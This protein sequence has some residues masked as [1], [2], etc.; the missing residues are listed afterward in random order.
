MASRIRTALL[1]SVALSIVST[2]IALAAPVPAT[3][4]VEGATET[5]VKERNQAALETNVADRANGEIRTVKGP[6]AL[7]QLIRAGAATDT[8][9]RTS[10]TDAFGPLSALVERVGPDDQGLNF[11]GPGFWLFKVNHKASDVGANQKLLTKG[12][13]VLWYFSSDF[14]VAEL[15]LGVPTKPV[16][17]GKRFTVTVTAYDGDGKGTPAKDARVAYSGTVRRTN[18][19]GRATFT[20]KR[21][22]RGMRATRG[23]DIRTGVEPMCGYVRAATECSSALP[24]DGSL[25]VISGGAKSIGWTTSAP[26]LRG[27]AATRSAPNSSL[28]TWRGRVYRGKRANGIARSLVRRYLS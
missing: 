10:F 7:G 14:E 16:K 27:L 26:V 23:D 24:F 25:R 8:P 28:V 11:D 18:A 21:G 9:I 6:S 13:D 4:R 5:L 20:A 1:G 2:T 22:T 19:K 3:I 17:R 15:D 12:D